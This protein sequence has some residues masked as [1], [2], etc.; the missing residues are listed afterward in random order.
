[1]ILINPVAKQNPTIF[2][3][4]LRLTTLKQ[5]PRFKSFN[6]HVRPRFLLWCIPKKR[7]TQLNSQ[8]ISVIVASHCVCFYGHA[9]CPA[10]LH[11]WVR[12]I[13]GQRVVS[14]T[15]NN[16]CILFR[17]TSIPPEVAVCNGERRR[18]CGWDTYSQIFS[19]RFM[20]FTNL[21]FCFLRSRSSRVGL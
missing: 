16:L 11:R 9:D 15:P 1:M 7:S 5:C 18:R 13:V 17:V 12:R 21:F 19:H 6:L 3:Y 20:Q 8:Y 4:K 2:T 10:C 14:G